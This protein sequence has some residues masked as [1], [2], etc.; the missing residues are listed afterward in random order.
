MDLASIPFPSKKMLNNLAT[1][2]LEKRMAELNNWLDQILTPSTLQS[3]PGMQELIFKFLDHTPYQQC[4]PTPTLARK[5]EDNLVA[6]IRSS[7]KNVSDAVKAVPDNFISTVDGV[8]DGI[9]RK[10]RP[11]RFPPG[12][13][14]PELHHRGSIDL[15]GEENIPLRIL[16]LL[17]D[18]VFDL[19][20][21]DQWFRRRLVLFL[22]QILKA[23]FGDIVNR[24][25]VD[26]VNALTSPEEVAGYIKSLK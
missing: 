16:L 22:R 25:I 24:K 12:H 7:V 2:F 1:W 6:P 4:Q 19:R 14:S 5:V 3:H 8:V 10:L 11:S 20:S 13:S 23:M 21:K 26:F 17:M 18:E 9:Y 15:E